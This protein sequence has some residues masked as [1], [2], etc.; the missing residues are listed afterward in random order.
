[1]TFC[2]YVFVPRAHTRAHTC[3]CVVFVCVSNYDRTNNVA[4]DAAN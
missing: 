2:V 4:V 3:V 1:M